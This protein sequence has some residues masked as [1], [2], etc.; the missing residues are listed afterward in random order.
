MYERP[1]VTSRF[2][3]YAGDSLVRRLSLAI[4]LTDD[5]TGLAPVGTFQVLLRE[6][7]EEQ[8][9]GQE[10][11]RNNSGF[12]CFVD[13]PDGNYTIVLEPG[14][15]AR[16]YSLRPQAGDPWSNDFTLPVALPLPN[17]LLPT[18][19]ITLTPDPGYRF[20]AHATLLRGHVS[21]AGVPVAGAVVRSS[22]DRATPTTVDPGATATVNV[23]S[24]T[25]NRGHYVLF[26]TAPSPALQNIQVTGIAAG[27]QMTRPATIRERR[28]TLDV[29]IAFP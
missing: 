17:P 6:R 13:I 11:I 16:F 12:F 25:N 22:Y 21:R 19:A 23:E 15:D 28:T 24:Q 29:D 20:P 5:F 14:T 7:R 1:F 27:Q 8:R 9:R 4:S 18:V 10:P 2:T 3:A 26:F